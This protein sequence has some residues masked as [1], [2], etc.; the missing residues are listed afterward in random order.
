[1]IY[2]TPI[3]S[4]LG[5]FLLLHWLLKGGLVKIA[6]DQ[7][8]QRSLHKVPV[9]RVGGLAIMA[10]VG[11][12]FLLQW[13][14]LWVVAGCAGMLVVVS[15]LDDIFGLPVVWRLLTH[16]AVAAGF[17]GFT[18]GADQGLIAE[19]ALFF[20][21]V[22]MINLYNFMD[23]SDG[24]AGGM[25]LIGFGFYAIAG[26]L[27]G[28]MG[29][30]TASASIAASALAFLL[31]NFHPAKVFMG[32]AGSIPLGFLA[33]ALG[34]MGWRGG[35]WPGW[36]PVM[37]FSPFI[38]DASLTLLKR[39]LRGEKVWQAHREHY[40][41][42]VVQMGWGHRYTALIEYGLMIGVGVSAIGMLELSPLYQVVLAAFWLVFYATLMRMADK[43]WVAF[44]REQEIH[45]NQH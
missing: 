22:W 44:V 15:L 8:N 14:G 42:R 37:I 27:H 38:L 7:P 20:A 39:L 28:E 11:M 12:G 2:I 17:L 10:G 3:F 35:V 9:P 16:G 18:L 32:D 34:I 40:Y 19:I 6:L 33:A 36:F 21:M 41:Q 4:F 31:F 1:M 5:T 30:A 23:G 26:Y 45:A 24:L 25:A 29:F 13:N 43:R